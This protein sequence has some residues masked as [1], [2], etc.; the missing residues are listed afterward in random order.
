[1]LGWGALNLFVDQG[2][3]YS[4]SSLVNQPHSVCPWQR[5]EK[6]IGDLN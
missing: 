4:D 6:K 2:E 1:V 5:D 3:F